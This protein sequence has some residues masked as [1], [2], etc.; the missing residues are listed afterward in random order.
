MGCG[1]EGRKESDKETLD[2]ELERNQR[3]IKGHVTQRLETRDSLQHESKVEIEDGESQRIREFAS[4][5]SLRSCTHE[6]SSTWLLKHG[7][8]KE[9]IDRHAK[10]DEEVHEGRAHQLVIQQQ[11][12]NPE[13][14]N[15]AML[16]SLGRLYLC[17]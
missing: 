12:V 14:T 16:Y 5:R 8:N 11:M 6:V 13:N 17:I 4:F 1:R 3:A 15:Q 9:G 10:V 7:L 2:R